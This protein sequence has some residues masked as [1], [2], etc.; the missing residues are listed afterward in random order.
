MKTCSSDDSV[1]DSRHAVQ[2][3]TVLGGMGRH[4]S[5]DGPYGY[6][7]V[8]AWW[9]RVLYNAEMWVSNTADRIERVAPDDMPF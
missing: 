3:G 7:T 8:R 9:G 4:I 5:D 2:G 6:G 1:S